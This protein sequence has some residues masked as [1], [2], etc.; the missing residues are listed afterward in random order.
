VNGKEKGIMADSNLAVSKCSEI[1][2]TSGAK[3]TTRVTEDGSKI[4]IFE[5]KN[6]TTGVL[7]S[8]GNNNYCKVAGGGITPA[9]YEN[10]SVKTDDYDPEK[11]T[12]DVVY[13][14]TFL[15][16]GAVAK[17]TNFIGNITNSVKQWLDETNHL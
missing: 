14:K 9:A 11:I 10:N 16:S 7:T 3:T 8:F 13:Q 15:G 17:T 4:S 12:Q 2:N 1:G 5:A 6:G